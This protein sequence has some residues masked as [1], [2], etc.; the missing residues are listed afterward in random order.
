M[1]IR[2]RPFA[3]LN[4]DIT[5]IRVFHL[6]NISAGDEYTINKHSIRNL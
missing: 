4:A 3:K 1:A 2:Y 5:K 6:G